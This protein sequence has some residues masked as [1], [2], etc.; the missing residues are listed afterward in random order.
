MQVFHVAGDI[1][2]KM[3]CIDASGKQTKVHTG[4][5]GCSSITAQVSN[6][7]T[8]DSAPANP[9]DD[10]IS[11]SDVVVG[12]EETVEPEVDGQNLTKF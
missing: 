8:N 11:E 5:Q 7:S 6:N 4:N 3:Q 2:V 10:D 1:N 9:D 12:A